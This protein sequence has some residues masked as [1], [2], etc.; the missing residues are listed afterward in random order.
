[1]KTMW[2]YLVTTKTFLTQGS[3]NLDPDTGHGPSRASAS[4]ILLSG[5]FAERTTSVSGL[6][7]PTRSP[8]WTKPSYDGDKS[9]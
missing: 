7:I 5:I 6:K 2:S 8:K 1:M 3:R 9:I 4:Y